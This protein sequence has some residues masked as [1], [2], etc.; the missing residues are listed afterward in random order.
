MTRT[1]RRIV[2]CLILIGALLLTS[3]KTPEPGEQPSEPIS[4]ADIVALFTGL[5]TVAIELEGTAVVMEKAPHLMPLL[6][7][8]KDGILEI[9]DLQAINPQDPASML[10]TYLAV[11]EVVDLIRKRR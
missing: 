8:D 5:T 7:T 10:R 11:R 2:A 6:D 3:C 9:S 1:Y 4:V